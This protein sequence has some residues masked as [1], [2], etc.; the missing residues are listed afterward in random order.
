M[1]WQVVAAAVGIWL[2]AAPAF[3]GFGETLSNVYHVLGPV[4][5]SFAVMAASAVLRVLRYVNVP[6]GLGVAVAPPLL[7]GDFAAIVV[8]LA[9]GAAL[10]VLSLLGRD[11]RDR[12]A[13]GWRSLFS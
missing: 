7:G 8:G 2:M 12:Y 1:W 10:V 4:A 6:L 3:L 13:G 11:E 9:S 5:A